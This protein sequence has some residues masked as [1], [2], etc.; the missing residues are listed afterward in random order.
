M[1]E[2]REGA[3]AAD[4]VGTEEQSNGKSAEVSALHDLFAGGIAGSASVVVGHPFDTIKVRMQT[5]TS[6]ASGGG[7]K[8]ASPLAMA[9][10]LF[11]GMGSP[12]SAAAAVNAI[13]FAS[14][15]SLTRLW[16]SIEGDRCK[17][18]DRHGLILDG[19]VYIEDDDH[20]NIQDV[21]S[22]QMHEPPRQDIVKVFSCG[23]GAGALQAF[24]ICPME[25]VKCRLQVSS[26]YKGPVDAAVSIVRQYGVTR[27]LFRGMGV[28]LWRETPAFGLYFAT[29]DTIKDRVESFLREQEE[30]HPIPAHLH[31]WSASALAGGLSGALTWFVVYP[32]DVIK[33]RIQTS[34]LERNLQR[35]MLTT[36]S[37][38]IREHGA[39]H[40]F[41]GLGVTL[42]RAFPVNAII[43]PVYEWVLLQL[44]DG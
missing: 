21:Q 37:D 17:H 40:M 34:P 27:G 7:V 9:R 18:V 26:A 12:L 19:A 10:S 28:T 42:V 43:F 41:R 44:G 4:P 20:R 35:S 8:S 36:V 30:S 16:E 15:G 5:N 31:A 39:G 3:A 23:S 22:S 14:Y 1:T 13:I 32:F 24:V 29:Y 25:H 33:S 6:I 11:S 2:L 38:I